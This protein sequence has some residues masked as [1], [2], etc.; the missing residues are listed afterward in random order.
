MASSQEKTE[1]PTEKRLRKARERGQL[2][3]SR[4]LT[5]V[6][7]LFAGGV[8]IYLSSDL[9]S[10]HFRLLMEEM[11]REATVAHSG[12]AIGWP[13]FFKV[14]THL[15]TMILPTLVAV[16]TAAVAINLAQLK[17][18]MFSPAAIRLN[19]SALNPIKGFGKFFTLRSITELV[20]SLIKITVI[21]T[22]V[23]A[24]LDSERDLL[25]SLTEQ[26]VGDV[27]QVTGHL[28][29]RLL[30]RVGWIMFIVSLFDYGYQ[31]WQ[32]LKDMK[33]TKQE[34]KEEHKETEGNPQIKS[35]IRSIQ[36]LLARQRMLANV[37][38]A[39]MVITNPTHYAVAMLYT[40]DMEAPQV[41][42]KGMDSLAQRIMKIARKHGVPVIQNPPLARALYKQVMLD[43][44]IPVHL[45]RAVA[46][47]LA[48]LHQQRQQRIG[49]H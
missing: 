2:A 38:K 27:M 23:Y 8:A 26:G 40:P 34:V 5:S 3:K 46:K 9:I 15:L 35:R 24:V 43:E 36:R 31:K 41:I 19:F 22:A 16:T 17:G 30:V 10:G 12:P 44:R 6:G 42:A 21:G 48:Y 25:L 18:F 7:I 1:K 11:L 13:V 37:P 20:K 29:F 39:S 47:V 28:G 32:H 14:V 49:N 4:E 33:M 45:Y